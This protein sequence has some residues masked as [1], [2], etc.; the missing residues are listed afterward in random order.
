MTFS[1]QKGDPKGGPEGGPEGGFKW[2][3]RRGSKK[4]SRRG[5]SRGPNE[6]PAGGPEWEVHVLYRPGLS[7]SYN[8]SARVRYKSLYISQPTYA[9]TPR[10]YY[11]YK[12]LSF[13]I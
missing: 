2:G 8:G 4:G 6:G 5:F 11:F 13:R 12:T 3:S 9:S 1:E 7:E 10:G